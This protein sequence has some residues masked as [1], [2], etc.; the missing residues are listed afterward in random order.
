MQ[1]TDTFQEIRQIETE[2]ESIVSSAEKRKEKLIQDARRKA[3][4]YSMEESEKL[5]A[6]MEEEM[7]RARNEAE[8]VKKN[9]LSSNKK[10]VGI[11]KRQA[12]SNMEKAVQHVLKRFEGL[13]E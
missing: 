13:L 7:A 4:E 8:S 11:L 5:K 3:V 9:I 10:K 6:Y 1:M 2:A 12:A